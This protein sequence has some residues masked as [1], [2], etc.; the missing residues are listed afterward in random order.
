MYGILFLM[1]YS[2]G[3][4]MEDFI[5][6]LETRRPVEWSMLPDFGIYMDQLL[7]YM[8]RQL[9]DFSSGEKLT[10]AMINNYIKDGLMPRAEGKRYSGSHIAYLT[11]IC[12]L[13]QAMPVKDVGALLGQAVH[14]DIS[15]FYEKLRGLLDKELTAAAEKIPAN[16]TK[17]E[18]ADYALSLGI[19]SYV[20][21]LVCK[22]LIS[23][24]AAEPEEEE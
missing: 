10:S 19:S 20:S 15:G 4:V 3:F 5:K 21:Q 2:G 13:K 17:D 7:A 9:V 23:R 14:E 1:K 8:T 18:I 16:M 11:A 24:L 6:E 12:V 22:E